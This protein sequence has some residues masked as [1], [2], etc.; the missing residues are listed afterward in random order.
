MLNLIRPIRESFKKAGR[1][2]GASYHRIKQTIGDVFRGVQQVAGEASKLIKSL[3]T[4]FKRS[5]FK[6]IVKILLAAL[7]GVGF[8]LGEQEW[9]K[10]L[11]SPISLTIQSIIPIL[12]LLGIYF[13]SKYPEARALAYAHFKSFVEPV[14]EALCGDGTK[15]E[16]KLDDRDCRYWGKCSTLRIYVPSSNSLKL[17]A[18]VALMNT[19]DKFE[20][21]AKAEI[22]IPEQNKTASSRINFRARTTAPNNDAECELIDSPDILLPLIALDNTTSLTRVFDYISRLPLCGRLGKFKEW[23]M[24]K[25][26]RDAVRE[27]SKELKALVS[28]LRTVEITEIN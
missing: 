9:F 4:S 21:H 3:A 13:V 2:I 15:I 19:R 11:E 27:F 25:A 20:E 10:Q 18:K 16:F 6:F 24:E 26:N 12:S 28:P 23:Q 8:F 17:R 5:P 7:S 14:G 22:T 1:I